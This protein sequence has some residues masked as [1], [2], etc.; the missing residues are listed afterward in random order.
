MAIISTSTWSS[1]SDTQIEYCLTKDIPFKESCL[2]VYTVFALAST[3]V[4]IKSLNT[5]ISLFR[6]FNQYHKLQLQ[7]LQEIKFTFYDPN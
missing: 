7:T 6:S 4:Q 3:Y 2:I 5:E 1:S